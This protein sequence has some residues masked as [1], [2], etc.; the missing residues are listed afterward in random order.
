MAGVWTGNGS[1][2]DLRHAVQAL[3]GRVQT[4][5]G[6]ESPI[7][8]LPPRYSDVLWAAARQLDLERGQVLFNKGDVGNG[9]YRVERGI[10][11]VVV[12]SGTGEERILALLGTGAIVGELAMLDGRPRSATV[13]AI[14]PSRVSFISRGSFQQVLA[15]RDLVDGLLATLVSRLRKSDE[16]AAAASFLSVRARVVRAL[17]QMAWKL[18]EKDPSSGMLVVEHDLR[19]TDIAALAGVSRESVTRVLA[20]LKKMGVVT[21]SSRSSYRIDP[22]RIEREI[23]RGG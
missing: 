2:V 19:Q 14:K 4:H 6:S 15:D 22:D 11:K 18:G 13:E 17:H 12:T 3:P 9:C 16:D 7:L 8:G 10:L 1:M 21:L 20:S 23:R 5:R